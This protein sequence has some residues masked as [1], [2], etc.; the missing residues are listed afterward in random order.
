MIFDEQVSRKLDNSSFIKKAIN[1]HGNKYDYS[2]VEYKR[3]HE[4]IKIICK[5]HGEFLQRPSSHI[6]GRGCK[7]CGRDVCSE[8]LSKKMTKEQL[9]ILSIDLN[10]KTM[11]EL[12]T[13][14]GMCDST[15][16][17]I[18]RKNNIC[19]KSDSYGPIC[20][21][22]SKK[23]WTSV[24]IGA[25]TR[26]LIFDITPEYVWSLYLKQNKKCSLSGIDISFVKSKKS[27]RT[28]SIDRTDNR[29]GYTI[30]N[31]QLVH[32]KINSMKSNMS[33]KDFIYFCKMV[34]GNN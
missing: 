34:G 28:A 6:N 30:D 23:F 25:K 26:N 2:L 24:K 17:K 9:S 21:E 4:K 14:T 16:R 11:K 10:N 3:Y 12:E 20:G 32:K 8:K 1:T 19:W 27:D 33:Q 22:I 18:M 5:I 13:N 31:I 7:K 29:F 15:I